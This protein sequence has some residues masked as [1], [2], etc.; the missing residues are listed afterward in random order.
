MH[1][2]TSW[3]AI[4]LLA[5]VGSCDPALFKN[6]LT[7]PAQVK[8]EPK[9]TGTWGGR[10]SQT[11]FVFFVEPREDQH[12]DVLLVGRGA[13]DGIGNIGFDA[14]PSTVGGKTYLNMREKIFT[15][16][17]ANKF[18]LKERYMLVRYELTADTLSLSYL[19]NEGVEGDAGVSLDAEPAVLAA[20]VQ[21][22]PASVFKH[23]QTFKRFKV[24][25]PPA[26][27]AK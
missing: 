5:S 18:T 4:L 14:F 12:L 27:R 6:P 16:S 25:A 8:A 20:G 7:D 15:D 9:L 21:R 1:S 23:F 26:A 22:L 19:E 10:D 13:G 24:P 17:F 3:A 2:I 11:E